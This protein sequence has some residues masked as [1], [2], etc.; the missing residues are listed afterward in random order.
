LTLYVSNHAHNLLFAAKLSQG[1]KQDDADDWAEAAA[2]MGDIYEMSWITIAATGSDSS[3]KGIYSAVSDRYKART[4]QGHDFQV[5]EALPDFTERIRENDNWPLLRRAWVYQERQLS[6]RT[7]HFG[8]QQIFWACNSSFQSQDGW[9]PSRLNPGKKKSLL[10]WKCIVSEY[11]ALQLSY[12]SD[13]LPAIA[14]IVL[15]VMQVRPRDTY[16]AGM[17]KETL[18]P[19]LSWY[20]SELQDRP[21]YKHRLP[22]WSWASASGKVDHFILNTP[23]VQVVQLLDV[24]FTYI[25]APHL[26]QVEDASITLQGPSCPLPDSA[27]PILHGDV[28]APASEGI[29][30]SST[31]DIGYTLWMDFAWQATK[32][33]TGSDDNLTVLFLCE[34]VRESVCVGQVYGG[35]IL[36]AVG[37]N[38]FERVGFITIGPDTSGY[39]EESHEQDSDEGN[40]DEGTGD[41]DDE[42]TH[43]E[44]MAHKGAVFFSAT[45]PLV[46]AERIEI[47]DIGIE[48]E[49]DGSDSDDAV[50]AF[51]HALPVRTFTIV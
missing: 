13:R 38:A 25:G 18:M 14:A 28:M 48:D 36:K 27:Y 7:V 9:Y 17:W 26:G 35:M 39:S 49:S 46:G 41:E 23:F 3:Q 10:D 22:T 5:R 34:Q 43:N 29:L 42:E 31:S 32:P 37:A 33:A 15:R 45:K 4:L 21:R 47:D 24:K 44:T 11:S 12:E 1:I 6:P 8:Q 19:D 30:V 40:S 20:V 2:T 16:I 50:F 51:V